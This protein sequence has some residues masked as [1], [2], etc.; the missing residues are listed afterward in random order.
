ML[1]AQLGQYGHATPGYLQSQLN[2]FAVDFQETSR[3]HFKEL[4][5]GF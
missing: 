5:V 3:R 2:K 1:Y 4:S